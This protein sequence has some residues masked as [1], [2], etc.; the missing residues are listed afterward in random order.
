LLT[1]RVRG[2]IGVLGAEVTL[3]DADGRLVA[4]RTIGAQLLTGCCGP[5]AVNL[6]IR[7][8]ADYR[9]A[10]RFSDG[11]T[12]T[13]PVDLTEHKHVVIETEY[14]GPTGISSRF[15]RRKVDRMLCLY[16]SGS[17]VGKLERPGLIN[18]G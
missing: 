8:P 18:P 2:K 9:L 14:R 16:A 6:A 13:W 5:T 4:R 17:E 11:T 10:V 7:H 3:S 15:R 12:R 1:V